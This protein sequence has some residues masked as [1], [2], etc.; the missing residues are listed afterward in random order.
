MKILQSILNFGTRMFY[1]LAGFVMFIPVIATMGN[2][3]AEG[4]EIYVDESITNQYIT[5]YGE[6]DIAAH[7]G[8][9]KLAPQNTLMA[10]ETLMANREV[11]GVDIAEFDVQLTK[12]GKLVLIHD[13]MYDDLSD[14]TEMFGKE[15]IWVS[16]LTYEEAR[17]LNMGERYKVNGEKPYNGL[18]GD[19]ID[20]KSVV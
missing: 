6:V 11:S 10:M 8:G 4:T 7:R 20:R 3:D 12:D 17:Q 5:E 2:G 19:E 15:N 13:L 18:R 9:A 16:S 1:V 14:A